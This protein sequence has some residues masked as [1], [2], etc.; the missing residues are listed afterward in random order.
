MFALK[1]SLNSQRQLFTTQHISTNKSLAAVSHWLRNL[2]PPMAKSKL[3]DRAPTNLPSENPSIDPRRRRQ[4]EFAAGRSCA[5]SL[6]QEFGEHSR[7]GQNPDRSPDWPS[8]FCGSISHSDNFVWALV[9]DNQHLRSI[10]IDTESIVDPQTC[11]L[12]EADIIS[13]Q[14]LAV[15]TAAGMEPELALTLAFS[16][17]EAFYK[18]WYPVNPKFFDFRQ[19]TIVACDE[20]KLSILSNS[21]NPNFMSDPG[22]L[23]V[24][25]LVHDQNVFSVSWMEQA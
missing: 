5:H 21:T 19:A 2:L 20:N 3:L 6:L 9:A 1:N 14:E 15:V 25:Y 13:E 24:P 8:G 4:I 18:C 16:A 22:T 23:Q 10:G 17:K 12:I 11:L 7:V